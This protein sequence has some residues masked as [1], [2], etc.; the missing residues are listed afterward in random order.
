MVLKSCNDDQST[1]EYLLLCSLFI[2]IGLQMKIFDGHSD[3]ATE[4]MCML[5]GFILTIFLT[6]SIVIY[7]LG[8]H[9]IAFI[10]D[11]QYVISYISYLVMTANRITITFVFVYLLW[12]TTR[13]FRLMND[14]LR[15]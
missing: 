7:T 8:F 5:G 1:S 4:I 14:Y 6:F 9:S 12:S 11:F 2:I 13:R 15:Y 3:Y 10:T